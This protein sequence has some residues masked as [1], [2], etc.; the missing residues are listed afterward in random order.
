M[1]RI[2]R[3][4]KLQTL[5]ELTYSPKTRDNSTIA[6][7]TR[8][9]LR[10]KDDNIPL[11]EDK[12]LVIGPKTSDT[13]LE[14]ISGNVST[15]KNRKCK[16]VVR[17]LDE[18]RNNF[19]G[20]CSST[21]QVNRLVKNKDTG[22]SIKR[23][24]NNATPKLTLVDPNKD[25]YDSSY[26]GRKQTVNVDELSKKSYK[27]SMDNARRY[28]ECLISES[29]ITNEINPGSVS[30]DDGE[31]SFITQIISRSPVKPISRI[32]DSVEELDQLE[33]ALEVLNEVAQVENMIEHKPHPKLRVL[34]TS[35]TRPIVT[36]KAV[37]AIS[38]KFSTISPAKIQL[39]S[40]IKNNPLSKATVHNDL[41]HPAQNIE[42][43]R[44]SQHNSTAVDSYKSHNRP[45]QVCSKKV[46]VKPLK[47]QVNIRFSKTQ[48]TTAVHQVPTTGSLK[49][50]ESKS[51]NNLKVPNSEND[52]FTRLSTG[53]YK[54]RSISRKT[55]E[56][57]TQVARAR[58]SYHLPTHKAVN[59]T[60]N[61]RDLSR[62]KDTSAQFSRLVK[63]QISRESLHKTNSSLVP[64]QDLKPPLGSSSQRTS[65]SH[66][67]ATLER[68]KKS[69]VVGEIR[70]CET[71]P[72]KDI[73]K[74][75]KERKYAADLA[76]AEAAEKGRKAVMEWAE[77]QKTK[78]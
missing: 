56:K 10:T 69:K 22:L 68:D 75:L 66:C 53:T 70:R 55:D 17:S 29:S 36:R 15:N 54:S 11:E 13:A 14:M 34:A 20:H 49:V 27:K 50:K 3:S 44:E 24:K 60:P 1:A 45:T 32:D 65:Y 7:S 63:S 41:A 33:T 46:A 43:Q 6:H 28:I 39:P 9:R 62:E 59:S 23:P 40:K 37:S 26:L 2:T 61:S 38:P 47:D 42:L 12:A 67:T 16:L 73:E 51:S 4:K 52:V 19:S 5:E 71:T 25:N 30:I 76:R 72:E 77:R 57:V 35:N 58:K 48:S 18:S 74:Q 64:P 78:R 31:D 8:T 21:K